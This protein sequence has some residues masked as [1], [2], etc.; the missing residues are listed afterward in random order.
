MAFSANTANCAI[1]HCP[2]KSGLLTFNTGLTVDILMCK[3]TVSISHDAMTVGRQNR[4]QG[5]GFQ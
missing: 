5:T 4:L 1:M 2:R 3:L